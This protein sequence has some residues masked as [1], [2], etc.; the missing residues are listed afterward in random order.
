MPILFWAPLECGLVALTGEECLSLTNM[1]GDVKKT[2]TAYNVGQEWR[3]RV[4]D[5]FP[6]CDGW[7]LEDQGIYHMHSFTLMKFNPS[8][9]D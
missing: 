5:S 1:I 3:I 2:L 6:D 7:E 9:N 8:L 4:A